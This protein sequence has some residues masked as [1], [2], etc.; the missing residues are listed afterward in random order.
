MGRSSLLLDTNETTPPLAQLRCSNFTV[1]SILPFMNPVLLLLLSKDH[2][3]AAVEMILGFIF[4]PLSL[5]LNVLT[6]PI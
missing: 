1:Q 2:E 3:T 4:L 5:K 6:M